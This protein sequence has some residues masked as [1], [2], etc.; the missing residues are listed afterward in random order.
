[1]N[2][3][4]SSVSLREKE[5]IWGQIRSP[6][7]RYDSILQLEVTRRKPRGGQYEGVGQMPGQEVWRKCVGLVLG[8]FRVRTGREKKGGS[9]GR[10]WLLLEDIRFLSMHNDRL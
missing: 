5:R 6:R 2:I 7:Q 4:S 1:M 10:C 3:P 9:P 8:G